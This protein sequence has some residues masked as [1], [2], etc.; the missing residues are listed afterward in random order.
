MSRF[1]YALLGV[2][3]GALMFA[4]GASPRS[5][6]GDLSVPVLLQPAAN[7][8][9]TAGTQITFQIQ[10]H[11]GDDLLWLHVSKSPSPVDR[12]VIGDD[13]ELEPFE[14]TSNPSIYEAKPSYSEDWAPGTYYWQAYRIE[15]ADN[16]SGRVVSEIRSFTITTPPTRPL[17]VARL[18]GSFD[19]KLTV[20]ATSGI[21]SVRRGRTYSER[22]T[23]TPRCAKGAC[24]TRVGVS[25]LYSTLG[26]W[27]LALNRS[28][29]L[30]RKSKTARILQCFYKPVRGPLTV[31]VRVTKGAWVDSEW[32]AK[33]ITGT[34]RHS[35][36]TVRSGIYRCPAGSIRATMRGT[37]SE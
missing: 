6:L 19:V 10:T 25:S 27:S 36:R 14:V 28:G 8:S 30:Y 9:F 23:F 12:G 24:R 29:A 5:S 33:R 22:W 21:K 13:V 37:L 4:A 1:A 16:P 15:Y 11:A 20:R 35:V 7:Q 31:K 3:V 2:V 26:G 34:F 32:R 18:E 17:R